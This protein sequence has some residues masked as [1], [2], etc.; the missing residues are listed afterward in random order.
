MSARNR[1]QA[2]IAIVRPAQPRTTSQAVAGATESR[3][4]AV[5]KVIAKKFRGDGVDATNPEHRAIIARLV[6]KEAEQH[7]LQIKFGN[8]A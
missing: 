8:I 6:L 5:E 1:R 2:E 4:E 3:V 7:H